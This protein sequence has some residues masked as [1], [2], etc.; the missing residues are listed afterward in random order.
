[1]SLQTSIGKLIAPFRAFK[2]TNINI[3]LNIDLSLLSVV[4]K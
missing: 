4:E 3:G 2:S 1:M